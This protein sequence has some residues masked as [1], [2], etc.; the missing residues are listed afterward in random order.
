MSTMTT[1]VMETGLFSA[2][3]H[4]I[5]PDD[6][7]RDV[8]PAN[9]W[10]PTASTV[11]PGGTDPARRCDEM[12]EDGVVAEVLYATRGLRVFGVQDP[13]AQEAVPG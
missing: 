12:A 11:A 2:D 6:L 4:V 8:L 10:G 9:F 13:A 3:S 7:W 5:E 1:T